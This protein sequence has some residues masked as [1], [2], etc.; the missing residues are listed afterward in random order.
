MLVSSDSLVFSKY[1]HATPS[2]Q[3]LSDLSSWLCVIQDV[4]VSFKSFAPLSKAVV[5][6]QMSTSL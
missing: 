4:G 3:L 6:K 5:H 2:A 1:L